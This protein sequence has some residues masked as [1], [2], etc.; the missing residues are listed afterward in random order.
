MSVNGSTAKGIEFVGLGVGVWG[1][2]GGGGQV[3]GIGLRLPFSPSY[4][5]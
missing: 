1:L 2:G 3:V 5:L 4:L